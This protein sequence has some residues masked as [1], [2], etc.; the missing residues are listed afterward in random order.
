MCS[1]KTVFEGN[2]QLTRRCG[3]AISRCYNGRFMIDLLLALIAAGRF[4]VRSGADAARSARFAPATCRAEMQTPTTGIAPRRHHS[5]GH[6]S[7]SML[8]QSQRLHSRNSYLRGLLGWVVILYR[9]LS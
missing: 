7:V 2:Q 4:F 8:T 9:A 3:S 1:R 6:V 5:D